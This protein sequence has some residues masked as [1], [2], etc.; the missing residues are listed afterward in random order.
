[1][2]AA[3][4]SDFISVEEYL[5]GEQGNDFRHEYLDGAVYAMAGGT[6]EHNQIAGNIYATLLYALRSGPCRP[7]IF[8]LK[9]RSFITL[10]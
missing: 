4:K 9:A 2:Q 8:D 3:L 7:F 6:Q 10:M 1:M 5:A